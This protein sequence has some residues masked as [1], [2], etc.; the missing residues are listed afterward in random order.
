MYQGV[1]ANPILNPSLETR[2]TGPNHLL[3]YLIGVFEDIFGK[4]DV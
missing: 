4:V 3:L 1:Q 2:G